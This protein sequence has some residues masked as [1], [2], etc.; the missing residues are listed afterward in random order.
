MTH[1]QLLSSIDGLPGDIGA[2]YV[3]FDDVLHNSESYAAHGEPDKIRKKI[4]EA[5]QFYYP[6]ARLTGTRGAYAI[7]ENC[8]NQIKQ[9]NEKIR[10]IGDNSIS[11]VAIQTQTELPEDVQAVASHLSSQLPRDHHIKHSLET[12]AVVIIC[13]LPFSESR[14]NIPAIL[15]E[16]SQEELN[17]NTR[18]HEGAFSI[19]E[20]IKSRTISDGASAMPLMY[21][22]YRARYEHQR[23]REKMVYP[24]GKAPHIW[25]I[26]G[27]K[28]ETRDVEIVA[29]PS[30]FQGLEDL[31]R[32]QEQPFDKEIP[33]EQK[34]AMLQELQNMYR[35]LTYEQ[36][37]KY[38]K[39][40][41]Q[42]NIHYVAPSYP[43]PPVTH[44]S[45]SSSSYF[46]SSLP[47]KS[48]P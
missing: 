11:E 36:F 24:D 10:N 6:L 34:W 27:G 40:M 31:C 9:L 25:N 45:V 12:P 30:V 16:T 37:C 23:R 21:N 39:L 5:M 32:E 17:I 38:L 15:A 48:Q 20:N 7:K 46:S 29:F 35:E 47:H 43:S 14:L 33:T 4:E 13:P 1:R 28:V 22:S 26:S 19:R 44:P 8:D 18:H 3:K 41:N 42:Y 2:L